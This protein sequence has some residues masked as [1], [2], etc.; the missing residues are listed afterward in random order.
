MFA[1]IA[2]ATAISAGALAFSAL[3]SSAMPI[4]PLS[5]PN[6]LPVQTVAWGCGVGWHPNPWGRCV[7]NRPIIYRHHW[8][9]PVVVY[10]SYG[11]HHRWRRHHDRHPGH[12]HHRHHWHR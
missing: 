8:H 4:A 6:A 10:R 12:W 5:A 9:R 7:P 2:L 1:K 11:W 3:P